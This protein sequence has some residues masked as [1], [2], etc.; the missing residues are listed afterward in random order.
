MIK[1]Q[2]KADGGY[3]ATEL[4]KTID[5]GAHTQPPILYSDQKQMKCLE[6]AQPG[7]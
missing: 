3:E 5:F 7:K 6:V 4:F 1:V 2:R